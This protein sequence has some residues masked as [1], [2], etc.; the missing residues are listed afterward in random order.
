MQAKIDKIETNVDSN[1]KN[2]TPRSIR[3]CT[4]QK[5]SIKERQNKRS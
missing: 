4:H 3:T 5:E 2:E 1:E